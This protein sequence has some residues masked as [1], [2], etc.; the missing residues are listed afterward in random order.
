MSDAAAAPG[1]NQTQ[2]SQIRRTSHQ[3]A[4]NNVM[5]PCL[6]LSIRTGHQA[7]ASTSSIKLAGWL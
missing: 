7:M 3:Q 4:P 6:H 2:G 5:P 1:W